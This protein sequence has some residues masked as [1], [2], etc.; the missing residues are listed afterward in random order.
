MA[1][2]FYDTV[3]VFEINNVIRLHD[4]GVSGKL[5]ASVRHVRRIKGSQDSDI[6]RHVELV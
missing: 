2:N 5:M 1:M 6:Q 4:Y 3:G